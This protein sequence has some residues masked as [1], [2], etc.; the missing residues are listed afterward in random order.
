M[1]IW[2]ALLLGI[3]Q[4]ITEFL[5]VSSSG[6]LVIIQE[7][8]KIKAGILFD[9]ILHIGSLIAV[10]IFFRKEIMRIIKSFFIND[11]E[12]RKLGFL[13]ITTTVFTGLLGFILKDFVESLFTS[14][15]WVGIGLIVTGIVLY[16]TKFVK[17]NK[18]TLSF[19]HSIIIGLVQAISLIP[20]I[21]RSGST[22]SAALYLGINREVA[23]RFSFLVFIPAILGSLVI[24]LYEEN[25]ENLDIGA[26]VI[27]FIASFIV[28][29]VALKYLFK[30]LINPKFYMFSY[31]CLVVGIII[32][33]IS[34]LL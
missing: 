32:S 5:P 10:L 31:Y 24:K 2:Q 33:V 11:K 1:D 7:L 25:L 29:L 12:N 16:L 17:E 27:G 28:S 26:L 18:R 23:A 15:L 8:F 20:G 6:H 4:G 3:V 9:I 14:T 13:I 21:S 22:I 34:I 19:K 30:L